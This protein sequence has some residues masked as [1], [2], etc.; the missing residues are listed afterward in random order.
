MT[1]VTDVTPAEQPD[2]DTMDMADLRDLIDNPPTEEDPTVAEEDVILEPTDGAG[3]TEGDDPDDDGEEA[4]TGEG[5]EGEEEGEAVAGEPVEVRTVE[6]VLAELEQVRAERDHQQ[7]VAGRNG[8]EAGHWRKQFQ[9]EQARNAELARAAA[10]NSAD[11]YGDPAPPPQQQQQTR[12]MGSQADAEFVQ[13]AMG[14]GLSAFQAENPGAMVL[15]EA[16]GQRVVDPELQAALQASG[17]DL[18]HVMESGDGHF[19]MQQ[20]Q[21]VLTSAYRKLQADRIAKS[22]AERA[23]STVDQAAKLK[24]KK[25]TSAASSGGSARAATPPK[26]FDPDAASMA[27]LRKAVNAVDLS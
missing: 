17:A 6:D 4:A 15:D 8:G 7:S 11:G 3:A 21:S 2:I 10:A 18:T 16:T 27:D 20:T 24:K 25:R 12:P 19:I 5:G 14:V 22:R 13:S 9:M 1:D 23:S 26:P